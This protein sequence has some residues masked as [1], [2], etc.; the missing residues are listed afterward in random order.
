[1]TDQEKKLHRAQL[2][3]DIEDAQGDLVILQDVALEMAGHIQNVVGKLQ[4]NAEL[5]PSVADFDVE[6]ELE[7]RLDVGQKLDIPAAMKV[8]SEMRSARQKV[9]TLQNRR[10]KLVNA[11]G[12]TV[13]S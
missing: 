2:L 11:A 4:R 6:S 7:N 8:I 10:S 3:I 9:Y 5:V 1:M 13:A 12:W